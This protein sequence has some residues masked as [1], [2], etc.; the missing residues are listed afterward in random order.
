M[1]VGSS[2][3]ANTSLVEGYRRPRIKN[4]FH[5][6][7]SF[8]GYNSVGT[9]IANFKAY[10]QKV[11]DMYK[12]PIWITEFAMVDPAFVENLTCCNADT[13]PHCGVPDA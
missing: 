12:L 2:A 10:I 7:A 8:P 13:V 11:H 4:R 9:A 1:R 5:R 3:P 6:T